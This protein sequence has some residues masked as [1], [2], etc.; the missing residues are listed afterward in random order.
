[1]TTGLAI[2]PTADLCGKKFLAM[3]WIG[4]HSSIKT[5]YK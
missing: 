4:N 3:G 2:Y 5:D 1:M